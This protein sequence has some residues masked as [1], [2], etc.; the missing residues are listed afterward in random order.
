MQSILESPPL[1]HSRLGLFD[2]Q[3]D[4]VAT[5]YLREV[6]LAIWDTGLGKTH[7]A[8]ATA[9]MLF[10]DGLID[11]VLVV[12]EQNKVAEWFV[13][14]Q[15]FTSLKT[16]KYM[17]SLK[18]RAKFR[19]EI[20]K[21]QVLVST[22]ETT[23]NDVVSK[24]KVWV[25]KSRR[26]V[27]RLIPQEL[28]E[29]LTGK[30]VLIVH[31]EVT[32]FG[33]RKSDNHKAHEKMISTLREEGVR[34]RL[35]GLT[36]TPIER[37]PDNLYNIG[38]IY[39]PD[40]IGTVSAFEDT[41]VADRNIFGQPTKW[42]NLEYLSDR[43]KPI[44]LRKRKTDPDVVHLFPKQVEE[45]AHIDLDPRHQEFYEVV[46]STFEGGD[47][48]VERALYVVFRQ[49]AGHPLSLLYSDSEV[50]RTIVETVG[51]AGLEALGAAKLERLVSYLTASVRDAGAQAVVFTFFGQSILPIIEAR[52]RDEGFSVVVNHGKLPQA[53]RDHN[54]AIFRAG[55]AEV[56]LTSDAGARGINL[57]EG[58]YVVQ[59]ELPCTHAN[60]VQRM[61]RIHRIDS[62][63]PTNTCMSFI[64]VN[65]VEEGLGHLVVKRNAWSD[66]LLDDDDTGENFFSAEQRKSLIKI[67]RR[68]REMPDAA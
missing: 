45:F 63:H 41:C 2:F 48:W 4:G 62:Q 47:P 5:C 65:T 25:Q 27:E 34:P 29:I 6:N 44:M 31:D 67:S 39:T 19:K 14:F 11:L 53:K 21:H 56:F 36:G 57:P 60:Y 7:L 12:C 9:A 10:E 28:T 8:M 61:N 52:L 51:R 54:K 15:K 13:D 50:A 42:H 32:K 30:R 38:R 20:A 24:V 68:N 22:Y 26:Y 33:D 49:I 16:L 23:K 66:V 64:A 55:G 59:Y 58:S 46:Q 40:T 37:G 43:I 17:G 18:Q 3:V 1:Y 35:L